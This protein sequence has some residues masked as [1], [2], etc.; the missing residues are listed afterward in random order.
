MVEAKQLKL[1]RIILRITAYVL[2]LTATAAV[3]G[4][5]W[6]APTTADSTDTNISSL[7]LECLALKNVARQA[8]Q[9]AKEAALAEAEKAATAVIKAVDSLEAGRGKDKSCELLSKA[10]KE[11]SKVARELADAIKSGAAE[12]RAGLTE[13]A[14]SLWKTAEAAEKTV[15]TAKSGQ[16]R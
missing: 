14:D 10:A 15:K 11:A 5:T 2:L 7:P 12:R 8:L 9:A 13:A 6:P 3:G 1:G 16:G 4:L